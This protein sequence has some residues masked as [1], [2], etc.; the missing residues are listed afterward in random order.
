MA[1]RLTN[2]EVHS[3]IKLVQR[4]MEHLKQGQLKMQSDISMIKKTLLDPDH[5]TISKVN[6]NTHFR[7]KANKALWSVWAVV[8]G[9]LA[10][11]I[12]WN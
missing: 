6:R 12:F 11:L 5:G 3:E 4:D 9:V 2:V 8:L 10:K 1:N 7:N